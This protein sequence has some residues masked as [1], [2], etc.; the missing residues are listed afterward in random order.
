MVRSVVARGGSG[1]VA[2]S[3][4]SDSYL[5]KLV[6]Y[7]PVEGLA[8]F[9]PLAATVKD[10]DARLWITFAV[11]LVVGLVLIGV[12]VRESSERPRIWFWPFVLVSFAAWSVGASETFRTMLDVSED[13]GGWFLGITAITLP[14]LDT[15][16]E[17]L[18][19]KKEPL[20]AAT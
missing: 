5:A 13:A 3:D 20:P 17:K 15:G 1:F 6:K 12:Q 11:A 2:S 9:L 4:D 16:L 7:V 8:P 18:T 19:A 10:S 14:A